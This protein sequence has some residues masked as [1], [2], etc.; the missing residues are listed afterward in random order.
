MKRT[1][2]FGLLVGACIVS[3]AQAAP[4]F[5]TPLGQIFERVCLTNRPDF[6]NAIEGLEAAGYV[7]A[8]TSDDAVLA[9]R[10]FETVIGETPWAVQ[11]ADR[12][13]KEQGSAAPQR[14]R[15]CTVIGVDPGN[16]GEEELRLWLGLPKP[17]A[18]KATVGLFAEKDGKRRLIT[19]APADTGPALQDGGFYTLA[20]VN[21]DAGKTAMLIFV[22]PAP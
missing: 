5:S 1:L 16:A 11:I 7:E 3:S 10:K 20:V 13:R 14:I 21:T 9:I 6:D 19:A 22:S 12:V 15:A 17:E 2:L 4:R 18:G 8:S